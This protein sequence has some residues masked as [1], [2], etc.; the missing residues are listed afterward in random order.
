MCSSVSDRMCTRISRLTKSRASS[1]WTMA[2]S[3]V[4]RLPSSKLQV[5]AQALDG[6]LADVQ[7]VQ[8][9]QVGKAV[10]EQ[11][12]LDQHV[13]VLHLADQFVVDDLAQVLQAPAFEHPGVQKVLVDRRQL[14]GQHR[15]EGADDRGIALHGHGPFVLI[16]HPR[17]RRLRSTANRAVFICEY[18][19]VH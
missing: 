14:V 18:L 11:H 10:Q 9:L 19:S 16:A 6:V 13:G 7:L 8:V 12:A 4:S 15:V 2:G 17:R 1:H 3:R 5:R